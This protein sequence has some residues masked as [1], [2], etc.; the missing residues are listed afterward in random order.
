MDAGPVIAAEHPPS[1]SFH[2]C[3]HFGPLPL[4]ASPAGAN[5][6]A[7]PKVFT[8]NGFRFHFFANEG[9]P[10]EPPHV[11]VRKGRDNAKF[12]LRPEVVVADSKGF[13]PRVLSQLT[14]VIENRREEI[15]GAWYDFFN[16]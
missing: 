4:S 2:R 1:Y 5:L 6:P 12:W 9:D 13:P 8:W 3:L 7:M 10:Q 11:H 14:G 15:E 16:S